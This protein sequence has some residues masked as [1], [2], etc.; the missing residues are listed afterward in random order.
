MSNRK[1]LLAVPAGAL[2]MFSLAMAQDAGNRG[3][4]NQRGPR[5]FDPAQMRE[6]M[7]NNMKEQLGASDDEWKVL[8]P[9]VEKVM[10]AQRDSRGGFGGFGGGRRG[11]PGGDRGAGGDRGSD[12]PQS[13][14]AQAQDELRTTLDNKSAS[15][16]EIS[17][18][19]TAYRE[20]REKAREELKA[21]QKELKELVT[22][23]QEATLVMMGM[24]E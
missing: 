6:R 8:T 3:G 2:L 11:G 16:D 19:L 17:K 12:R 7:M 24:L 10:T 13:K 21:A 22:Q 1:W 14:V 20:A 18:K 23:R 9:K 5:N 4:D 15:A